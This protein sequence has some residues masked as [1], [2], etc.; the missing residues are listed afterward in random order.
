[1]IRSTNVLWVLVLAVLCGCSAIDRLRPSKR[2][3]EE[4][5]QQQQVLQLKVM[6]FADQYAG[7]EQEAINRL[8]GGIQNPQQRLLAQRWMLQQAQSAYTIASGPSAVSNALD[9]VVLATM[10]RMVVDGAGITDLYGP[11]VRQLRE[12]YHSLEADAWQLLTGVLT[13][14]QISRLRVD[15]EAW[16]ARNP[17]VR[18]VA[19]VHFADFAKS[20]GVAEAEKGRSDSLLSLVGL[21]PL[22]GLDPAVQQ[23]AQTRDLAERSIY[24]MQRVPDLLHM[25]VELMVYQSAVLPETRTLLN[26]VTRF[27]LVGSSSDR[28]VTDL[29]QVLDAQREGVVKDLTRML[30][31]ESERM[32]AL[33]GQLRATLQAGTDTATAVQGML[34]TADK[35]TAQLTANKPG[36]AAPQGPPF[37]IREYTAMLQQAALTA[38]EVNTLAHSADSLLPGL[39]SATQDVTAR[40]EALEN[41]LSVLLVLIVFA[42]AASGLL[43]AL[44]YRRIVVHWR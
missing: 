37:D 19:Y 34:A 17:D 41:R 32:I 23:I 8:K 9:M 15:I 29:P 36:P 39:R 6:R 1:M 42:A 14:P 40:L 38:R 11:N 24:Y 28:L 35:I 44:A 4:R 16:H 27:S 22:A 12:T 43:A 18:S 26:D 30:N 25:Q 20:N 2:E 33:T 3:A 5:A 21:N 7:L 10:S 13:D 31:R